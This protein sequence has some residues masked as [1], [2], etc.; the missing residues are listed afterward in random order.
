[1]AWR[2]ASIPSD[3]VSLGNS[4][5]PSTSAFIVAFAGKRTSTLT[6]TT[7]ASE[8]PTS[9]T[10]L[11]V[12]PYAFNHGSKRSFWMPNSKK[13]CEAMQMS[14]PWPTCSTATRPAALAFFSSGCPIGSQLSTS[15]AAKWAQISIAVHPA[16]RTKP[17]SQYLNRNG[18]PAISSM[19]WRN[20][21][22]YS[23]I[24]GVQILDCRDPQKP[25]FLSKT[26]PEIAGRLRPMPMPLWFSNLLALCQAQALG[27][28]FLGFTDEC[29]RAAS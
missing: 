15:G 13:S 27:D 7:R 21:A 24:P 14:S 6:A 5:S 25:P 17:V 16:S 3:T 4:P 26:M 20:V 2:A 12:G 29:V 23:P 10:R 9:P 22:Q 11:Q 8:R 1:M 28:H 19:W 18:T